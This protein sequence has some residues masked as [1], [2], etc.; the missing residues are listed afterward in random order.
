[1]LFIHI[2]TAC[3]AVISGFAL[4]S[5]SKGTATHRKLGTI[6]A[7]G[8]LTASCSSLYLFY[9][10]NELPLMGIL[11][12]YLVLTSWI[13]IKRP[14]MTISKVDWFLASAAAILALCLYHYAYSVQVGKFEGYGVPSAVYYTFASLTTAC[15]ALDLKVI[16][17]GGIDRKQRITRHL[18]R[19]LTAF[20]LAMLSVADQKRIYPEWVLEAKLMLIPLLIILSIL[21]CWVISMK[22]ANEPYGQS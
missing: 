19:M 18:W 22:I 7:L 6:F 3:V 4:L 17:Q 5:L 10:K 15:A 1:M 20:L 21:V 2:I 14:P 12:I 16:F 13:T 11:C 9:T 8:M